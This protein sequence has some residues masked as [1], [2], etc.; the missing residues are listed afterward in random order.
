MR[1]YDPSP[2]AEVELDISKYP[3]KLATVSKDPNK[4]GWAAYRI[5]LSNEVRSLHLDSPLYGGQGRQ[6]VLDFDQKSFAVNDQY[7]I[8]M[9]LS[10]LIVV[11]NS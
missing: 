3:L 7:F 6:L 4:R 5:E 1:R 10:S 9:L 8:F 11:V 2:P